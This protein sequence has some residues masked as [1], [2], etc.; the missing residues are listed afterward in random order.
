MSTDAQLPA[1]AFAITRGD[2]AA[3]RAALAQGADPN[4]AWSPGTS[5]LGAAAREGHAELVRLLL[6]HGA[7]PHGRPDDPE[8][9]LATA[10]ALGERAVVAVLLAGGAEPSRSDR[11]GIPALFRALSGPD[12]ALVFDLLAVDQALS[13]LC[14]AVVNG[15]LDGVHAA[16]RSDS[17]VPGIA[18]GALQALHWAGMAGESAALGMLLAHGADPNARGPRGWTPLM[19]AA[20]RGAPDAVAELVRHE[21]AV[22]LTDDTSWAA[23]HHAATGAACKIDAAGTTQQLLAAGALATVRT[24]Y[25]YTPLHLAADGVVVEL[26]LA[27]GADREARDDQGNTPLIVAAEYGRVSAVAALLAAGAD[28]QAINHDGFTARGLANAWDGHDTGV[29]ALLM[30]AGATQ[31]PRSRR[32]PIR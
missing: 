2:L 28:I 18:P 27:A 11:H 8:P 26:L 32:R 30:Q 4:A 10:A 12:P 20:W 3:A 7:V 5:L 29:R 31:P 23:L 19:L 17:G 9:P 15:D 6:Q 13:P 14:R 25:G 21:A 24:S 22:E 1:L 16:L